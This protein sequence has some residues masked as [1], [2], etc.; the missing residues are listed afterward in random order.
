[1]SP[2]NAMRRARWLVAGVVIAALF[3]M[4]TVSLG[5]TGSVM[6]CDGAVPEWMVPPGYDN[7]GCVTLR[8]AWEAFLP[9]NIGR[10]DWYCLGY[11]NLEM[12]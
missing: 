10:N 9:W 5:M 6:Q 12:D 2:L 3:F 1:M 11:C 8:P 4:A 7:S